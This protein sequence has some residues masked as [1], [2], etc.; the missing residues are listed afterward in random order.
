MKQG[1]RYPSPPL[2][3]ELSSVHSKIEKRD[4]AQ[5][6]QAFAYLTCKYSDPDHEPLKV[7]QNILSGMGARLWTEVR[8]KRSLAYTVYAYQNAEALAG[9]FDCYLATSPD[10]ALE[11][12][13]LAME[14][15][16]G[17]E[18]NPPT[19]EEMQRSINYTAGSFSIYLQPNAIKADLYT[20]WELEGKGFKA[21]YEYPDKI[22]QVTREQVLDVAGRYFSTPYYGLGMVQGTGASVK[23]RE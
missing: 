19:D 18:Q 12:R 7:A 4:R 9:S 13:K 5:T 14:V 20:R 21:V 17:L 22:R 1:S 15:I 2:D 6:A 23:Q 3:A 11:A 10:K 8:D 16:T